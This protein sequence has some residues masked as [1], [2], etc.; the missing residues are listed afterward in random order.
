MNRR[1][2]IIGA[3]AVFLA[4][5]VNAKKRHLSE[6]QTAESLRLWPSTPPGGGGPDGPMKISQRGAVSN[7]ST[8]HLTVYQP[9]NP[10]GSA[11]LIAAG[12]G[13]KRIEMESEAHP[14]AQ[15]LSE[16][17]ITAFVLT[18]R[19]P[20]EGWQAGA[21]APLQDAQRALRL[22][23]ANANK[24]GI[25]KDKLGVLGFSAGGHLLGMASVRAD[26][27]SYSAIDEIDNHSAKPDVSA[28]IY[29]IITLEA[30][31]SDTSTAHILVGRHADEREAAR[32]SVQNF[33][34]PQTPPMF[35]AQAK[36]DP[37]SNPMN[38]VIMKE[39]CDK[40]HVP[41]ELHQ[42]ASGGHGF[43]MGKPGT[44]TEIWPHFYRDWLQ[45]EGELS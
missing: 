1:N 37:I 14:A 18:Y 16:R 42:L 38:T 35:L 3:S 21:M 44:P 30:P 31:Y 4:G 17:G 12:G 24:Y 43:G 39:A 9:K 5:C 23:R 10:N 6:P 40:M 20:N 19:L 7:V 26:F 45:R 27:Q 25:R 11:M 34:T 32:W 36:D 28:L 8:P 15:W 29:P 13:Y 41:C 2:F 33:V 22:I